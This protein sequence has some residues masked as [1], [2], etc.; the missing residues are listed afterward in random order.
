MFVVAIVLL[1][2]AGSV[3]LLDAG[4]GLMLLAFF[5]LS[6]FYPVAFEVWWNGQTP[7]KRATDLRVVCDD[8]TPISIP[9]S[10]VRNFLRVADVL[11]TGYAVGLVCCLIDPSSRRLGD[12]AAGTLV[13]YASPIEHQSQIDPGIAP[14]SPPIALDLAEERALISYAERSKLLTSERV[15][16]LAQTLVPLAGSE[17]TSEKLIRMAAWLQGNHR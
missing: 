13:V 5:L 8:G 17:R 6:W 2:A 4:I 15:E 16:E 9:K 7:G 3:D 12:L 1:F 14:L 10:I 11:P